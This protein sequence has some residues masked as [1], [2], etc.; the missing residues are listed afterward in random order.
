MTSGLKICMVV[1]KQ[2][3]NFREQMGGYQRG[4][5]GGGGVG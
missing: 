1:K 4:R 2:T 3:L 5:G